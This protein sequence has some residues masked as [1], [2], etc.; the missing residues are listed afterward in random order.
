MKIALLVCA[1]LTCTIAN[2]GNC[3]RTPLHD[4]IERG[5]DL[6]LGENHGT[7][8][9]PALVRC[10]V[11]AAVARGNEKVIVS[12]EQQSA[13]RDLAGDIWRG[14]DGRSSA[15]MWELTRFLLEQEKLGRL[16]F[17]QH[18]FSSLK[19]EEEFKNWTPAIHDRDMGEHLR[20]LVPQGQLIALSGDFHSRKEGV[21]GVGYDPAGKYVGAAAIHVDLLFAEKG[22]TWNCLAS[23]CRVHA[24]GGEASWGPAGALVDGAP[25]Q[26]DHIFLLGK[27]TASPPKLPPLK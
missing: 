8:E 21:A 12:L 5:Q 18:V 4:F 26:H 15:A 9:V 6:Y 27:P 11:E 13:A 7:A 2:A 16:V 25:T 19:T 22:T 24:N 1:L 10:L 14:T 23:E 3:P 17:D 20:A